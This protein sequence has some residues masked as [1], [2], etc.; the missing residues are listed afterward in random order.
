VQRVEADAVDEFRRALDVPDREVARFSRFERADLAKTAERARRLAGR[1]G[2]AF[3]DGEAEQGRTHVHREEKRGQR[4]GARVAVR[5]QRDAGAMPA[6]RGDRR[7]LRFA[8]HVVGAGQENRHRPGLGHR[9][10]ALLV[11]VFEMIRR[12]RAVRGG[13]LR[14]AEIGELVGVE[15]EGK[16][17]RLRR[18]EHPRGLLGREGDPLAEGVDRIGE[19]VA[20]DRRQHLLADE[21]D[22]GIL[23]AARFRRERMRA[24][25]GRDDRDRPRAAETAR[26]AQRAHLG[27]EVE[28]VAG[29]HLDRRAALGDEMIE[30]RQRFAEERVLGC[31]PGRLDRGHDA[32]A[33]AG[34][35]LVG[36][37]FQ[38]KLEFVRAVAAVNEVGVTVDEARR[39]PAALAI[40]P[41]PRVKTRRQFG[42]LSRKGDPPV[43]G[44][45]GA[46]LDGTEAVAAFGQREEAGIVP[47]R[48]EAHA[49]H[50]PMIGVNVYT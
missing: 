24:E 1:S 28:P 33:G 14:P 6:E 12:E 22:I 18:R 26:R 15:L 7:S 5:R 35:L 21:V 3:L 45:D 42:C 48:V 23:V 27:V 39:D 44:G 38:A 17:E 46:A 43:N 37:A 47:E 8:Q 9:G 19:A 31:R 40:D 50:I 10:R 2:E 29:L 13:E 16:A 11:G 30:A 34:D 49:S 20:R 4:R 36:R 25:E 32:A 41:L